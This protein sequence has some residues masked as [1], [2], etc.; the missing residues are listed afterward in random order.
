MT[1]AIAFCQDAFVPRV[2]PE[3]LSTPLARRL[4]EALNARGMTQVELE[5]RANLPSGYVSKIKKGER[6]ELGPTHL[7]SIAS[8]L[9]VRIAWLTQGESPRDVDGADIKYD[10]HL[11]ADVREGIDMAVRRLSS[12]HPVEVIQEGVDRFGKRFSGATW[13]SVW[14]VGQWVERY[15]NEVAT[16][17]ATAGARARRDAAAEEATREAEDEMAPRGRRSK[18]R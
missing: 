14:E 1:A 11:P 18:K 3:A 13:G 4:F 15:V 7:G 8:V 17:A 5:E 10:P 9:R 6:K 12:K 2:A 16:E